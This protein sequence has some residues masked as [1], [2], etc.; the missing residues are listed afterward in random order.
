MEKVV[1]NGQVAVLYSPGFGAGWY[2]WNLQF[3]SCL[4]DPEIVEMVEKEVPYIDIAQFAESKYGEDF[5]SGGADDLRIMWMPQGAEFIIDEF[6]GSESI[7]F[8]DKITWEVA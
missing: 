6:D 7:R 2:T 8:K 1:R 3:L 4:Y 5:Y